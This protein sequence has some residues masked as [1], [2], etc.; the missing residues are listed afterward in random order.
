MAATVTAVA[1]AERPP[2][3]AAVCRRYEQL[4]VFYRGG[5]PRLNDIERF[6]HKGD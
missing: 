3:D 5:L 2:T 1:T 4:L 6:C